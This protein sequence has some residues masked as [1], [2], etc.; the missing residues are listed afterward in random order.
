MYCDNE[1]FAF[2][3]SQIFYMKNIWII[4]FLDLLDK[5][6]VIVKRILEKEAKG[7]YIK[8]KDKLLTELK[9]KATTNLVQ[10]RDF[11]KEFE[12]LVKWI[13]TR[14][15]WNKPIHLEGMKLPV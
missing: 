1:T 4:L 9:G 3:K 14:Q 12:L 11:V 5:C 7:W 15:H 8:Y 13:S 6:T 10:R 2:T